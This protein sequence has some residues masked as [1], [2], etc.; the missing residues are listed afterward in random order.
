MTVVG[1]SLK[2]YFGLTQTLDWCTAVAVVAR[3]ARGVI[4]GSTEFF[5]APTVPTLVLVANILAS[6]NVG[7]G[8]QD[9]SE[10]DSGPYTGEVSGVTL[11]AAGCTYVEVG[12]A[13]RRRLHGETH[14]VVASKVDAALRNG[15]TPVLCVGEHQAMEAT[16]AAA[17]AIDQLQLA[18]RRARSADHPGR[19]IVAYEPVW[20]IGTSVPAPVAHIGEVCCALRAELQASDGFSGPVIYGGSAGPGL[21]GRLDGAIDGL[22]LGRFA[23]D[24]HALESV[25]E[26][27]DLARTGSVS[28][29]EGQGRAPEGAREDARRQLEGA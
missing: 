17:V 14:A 4:E 6:A 10:H 24:V 28:Y 5:V 11:A 9:L 20:A 1:V 27:A 25:L 29:T 16:S 21:I 7:L 19:V 18:L 8:A 26:E 3:R 22:F 12:H 2:M 13:E 15:L 23:H